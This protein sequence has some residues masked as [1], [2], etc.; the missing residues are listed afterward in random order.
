VSKLDCDADF[1][2]NAPNEYQTANYYRVSGKM[3]ITLDSGLGSIKVRH[4]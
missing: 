1:E 4:R 3:N 2:N